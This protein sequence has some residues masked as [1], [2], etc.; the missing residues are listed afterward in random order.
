MGNAWIREVASTRILEV[1]KPGFVKGE[2]LAFVEGEH[3]RSV[4]LVG[5]GMKVW[6]Q[7]MVGLADGVSL[8]LFKALDLRL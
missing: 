4:E 5:L 8:R 3:S 1:R 2:L 7:D 6:N